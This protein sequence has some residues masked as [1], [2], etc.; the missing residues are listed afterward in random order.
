LLKVCD[1]TVSY[2]GAQQ[3]AVS[4][5]SF[6]VQPGEVLGLQG[7][8]GCGKTSTAL[9]ILGL[10][11]PRAQV[12][13]SVLLHDDHLRD[14]DLLKLSSRELRSLRGKQI[15]I[16]YQEPAIALNPVMRVGDQIAEIVRAH[17][18]H[19]SRECRERAQQMLNRVRL[20]SSRFYHAYPHEIS[21]GERHRVILAQALACQP[22]LVI[23]DE[24]TAGLDQALKH[25]ILD[26]IESMRDEFGT[27][28]LLIS[29][30]HGVCSRVADRIIDI[31]SKTEESATSSHSRM[32]REHT[33]GMQRT[34]S[35][36]LSHYPPPTVHSAGSSGVAAAAMMKVTPVDRCHDQET[37]VV[38][39]RGLSK[40]YRARGVFT[41]KHAEKHALDCVDLNIPAGSIVGL[42][43][44]SGSGKSTLA[45][46]L[47]LLE[48]A[49]SGEIVF[50]G[51]NLLCL[52]P[53]KLRQ[54]RPRF[55]YIAQD[56]AMALNPRLSAAEAVAE[57]MRIQESGAG[58]ERQRRVHELM[59][60]V[61]LDP[62]MG[63]RS[64]HQFSGGQKQRLAI[65]RALAL[66]P[67]LLIFDESLSG[68]DVETQNGI[69][70]LLRKLK[71]DL[72]VTQVLISHD[73][74]LVFSIA[75]QV[76]VMRNGRIVEQRDT[77]ILKDSERSS[78]TQRINSAPPR[79]L[80][81]QEVE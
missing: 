15:S 42:I 25:E 36:V 73:L 56:P 47:S 67:K 72:G 48:S 80:L 10:L 51:G 71:L 19:S 33:A 26:L 12:S 35:A 41:R 31:S 14:H 49:D 50:E 60:C 62:A 13:G 21:G 20:D 66:N 16:L 18:S 59:Q 64:C 76:A 63:G 5:L 45:R 77:R 43:G 17:S 69:V 81:A 70:D 57:P 2:R 3:P 46:C 54:F 8:S 6:E 9:A 74:E 22:L 58:T 79:E 24:P 75:D 29:H 55:Q 30:D 11:P 61:G 39:I 23:A 38:S 37:S 27:A 65:A 40:W 1:L 4:G 32:P 52:S 68:L 7:R 78:T 28:F 34:E 44:A 53:R